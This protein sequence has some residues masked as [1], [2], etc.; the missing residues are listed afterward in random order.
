MIDAAKPQTRVLPVGH[1]FNTFDRRLQP[2]G[3]YV[4]TGE[5]TIAIT[6]SGGHSDGYCAEFAHTSKYA[7]V[8]LQ[9]GPATSSD[10]AAED[11][12]SQAVQ[13]SLLSIPV[14]KVDA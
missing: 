8:R 11:L 9:G 5:L 6:A 12:L 2:V 14:K 7:L 3:K 4:L 1:S 13:S 10:A